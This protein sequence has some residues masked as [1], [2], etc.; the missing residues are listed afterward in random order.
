MAKAK[1]IFIVITHSRQKKD[2]ETQV[3]EQC[4]FVDQLRKRDHSNATVIIDYI[5]EK[6][7]KNR[8]KN[9]T[10]N[11]FIWYVH[12]NYP[13]QMGELAREFKS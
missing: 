8:E 12:K 7:I 2:G 1:K 10:Y 13:Q 11:D 5:N 6:I 3:V 4:E 9:G